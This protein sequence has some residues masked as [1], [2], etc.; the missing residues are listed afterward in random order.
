LGPAPWAPPLGPR[1]LGP[2]PW[3][4]PLGPRPLGP[5]P[6]P[7][8]RRAAVAPKAPSLQLATPPLPPLRLR[9]A[10]SGCRP[11]GN[12]PAWLPASGRGDAREP[13]LLCCL[14]LLLA[15]PPA[16]ALVRR[17]SLPVLQPCGCHATVHAAPT[18]N[19]RPAVHHL[20]RA[21]RPAPQA[22]TA[23]PPARRRSSPRS[24]GRRT[25]RT[26][27]GPRPRRRPRPRSGPRARRAAPPCGRARDAGRGGRERSPGAPRHTW[28]QPKMGPGKVHA[29]PATHFLVSQRSRNRRL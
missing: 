11:R 16:A 22:P 9:A 14:L 29:A 18:R 21:P 13:A 2:A 20:T 1:P 7:R 8:K 27:W 28:G 23:D 6:R 19:M 12:S 25:R 4:P 15:S 5:A 3:A 17:G 24:Q 10:A 26:A